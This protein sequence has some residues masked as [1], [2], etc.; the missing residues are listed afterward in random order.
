MGPRLAPNSPMF[1]MPLS[2][3]HFTGLGY[4]LLQCPYA[5]PAVSTADVSSMIEAILARQSTMIRRHGCLLGRSL[6]FPSLSGPTA[7]RKWP[8]RVHQPMLKWPVKVRELLLLHAAAEV[9]T[10]LPVRTRL[11]EP[12]NVILHAQP[13]EAFPHG[14]TQRLCPR[15]AGRVMTPTGKIQRIRRGGTVTH[16]KSCQ[17]RY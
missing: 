7:D 4:R 1:S 2:V 8:E 10:Q 17:R 11:P 14:V 5:C 6:R 9:T 3:V 16:G 15:M 12:L 13:R